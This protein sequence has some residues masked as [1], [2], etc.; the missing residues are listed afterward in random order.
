MQVSVRK[1]PTWWTIFFVLSLVCVN[2][3]HSELKPHTLK[4]MVGA[5]LFDEGSGNTATDT[6][7]N[8]HKGEIKGPKW[9]KGK[10]NGALEFDGKDDIVEIPHDKAFDLA[11]YTLV[12]WAQ[13]VHNG[14]Y[15][16][17]IGKEPA[18]SP[19]SFGIFNTPDNFLGV[20][21]TQ[22]NGNQWKGAEGKTILAEGTWYHVAARYDGK[23]LRGYLNGQL[24]TEKEVG[25]SPDFNTAPVRIG[26]WGGARGD[27]WQGLIDE[28]AIFNTALDE[29]EI[30]EIMNTGLADLLAV[31]PAGKLAA[32]WASIKS[33]N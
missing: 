22:G 27:R 12:A 30:Q 4:A 24:E 6:S 9:A 15:R 5:W 10:Y 11:E 33:R 32:T 1:P 16:T 13:P 2:H 17:V 19:R 3:A 23:A 26:R 18:E 29:A 31:E 25:G 7:G 20:N 28:V 14:Q 8:G 21:F